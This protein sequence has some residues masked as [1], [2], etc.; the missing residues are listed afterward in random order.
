MTH[1][2]RYAPI[3][4][5]DE[6]PLRIREDAMGAYLMMFAAWG[7]GLPLPLINVIAAVIYYFV[8]R[9]KGRFVK[10]HAHQSMA[11]QV[12][13]GLVNAGAV[14]G[15]FR[16]FFLEQGWN[17][18]FFAYLLTVI[19]INVFYFVFSIIAA[20]KAR[21]GRIYYYWFFGKLAY[22]AAFVIKADTRD[23]GSA[24]NAPPD[25]M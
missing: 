20:V 7:V 9:N 23:R 22:H 15:L 16:V 19:V 14:F 13:V 4:Q 18:Y 8:N 12:A 11:S 25:N 24:I 1:E 10:Y 21:Q 17:R 6:L 2:N 3:P 5:P